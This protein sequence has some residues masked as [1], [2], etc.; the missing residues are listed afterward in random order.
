MCA[1]EGS[2]ATAIGEGDATVPSF[3]PPKADEGGGGSCKPSVQGCGR[4][5]SGC[6]LA[7]FAL[8]IEAGQ[9]AEGAEGCWYGWPVALIP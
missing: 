2:P 1:G 6:N 5:G 7:S 9:P 8:R 3:D 4:I